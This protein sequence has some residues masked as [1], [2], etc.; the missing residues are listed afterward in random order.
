M[1]FLSL[2][3]SWGL[4]SALLKGVSYLC[5]LKR[6]LEDEVLKREDVQSYM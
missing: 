1:S 4:G 6:N 5:I 3:L 2:W